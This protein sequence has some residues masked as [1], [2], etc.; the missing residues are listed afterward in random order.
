[1]AWG[2]LM[3]GNRLLVC[4]IPAPIAIDVWT[5]RVK[6]DECMMMFCFLFRL[7]E[8]ILPF[9]LALVCAVLSPASTFTDLR[10][11]PILTPRARA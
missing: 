5:H 8:V 1:M 6:G 4:P 3:E 2:L 11:F 7:R 10:I 9:A